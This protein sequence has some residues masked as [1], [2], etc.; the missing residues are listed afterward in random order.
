MLSVFVIADDAACTAHSILPN[1][2]GASGAVGGAKGGHVR[3]NW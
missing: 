3:L 2:G 1:S